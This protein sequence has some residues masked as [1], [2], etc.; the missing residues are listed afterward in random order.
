MATFTVTTDQN[1]D[2]LATKAGGD[3]YNVNGGTLRIDT[4]TRWCANSSTTIGTIGV[5]TISS[6]LGGTVLMDG[7]KVRLIPY[8]SGTG[9]V[10][11]AGT[12]ISQGGVSAT[13]LC[14]M[15][16]VNAV[17]TA[18]G[19]AMPATGFIKVKNKTGGN[20]AAGALSGI[21]ASATGADTVG[22]IEV[23]ADETAANA[24]TI[25]RL[26]KWQITGD[27]YEAGTT[28]GS[29][30]QTFQLPNGTASAAL[31]TP[32]VW[33]ETSSG[34]GEYEFW[35]ALSTANGFSTTNQGTDDRAK[36]VQ[37][38]TGG[39]IRIGSDGTNNIGHLPPTGCKVRIPN[40]ILTGNASATRQTAVIP[41]STIA[42]RFE[43]LTTSA[44]VI[45][46]DK[47]FIHWYVNISQA[48][49]VKFNYAGIFDGPHI[50]SEVASPLDLKDFHIVPA[51]ALDA[52]VL[53]L[54]SCFAGGTVVDCKWGRAGTVGSGDHCATISYC[55]GQT[56]TRLHANSYSVRTNN[57]FPRIIW[58]WCDNQ[59]FNDC[60]FIGLAA[61]LV[62]CSNVDV[63]NLKY[64][65]RAVAQNTNYPTYALLI[66]T[67]C[68]DV[69]VDGYGTYGST[70]NMH[71][72]S[73]L[74]SITASKNIKIR[75]IGTPSSPFNMGSANAS[76]VVVNHGGNS[77]GI[78]VKRVYVQNTRTGI[79]TTINSDTNVLYENVWG[80]SGDVPN[81]QC[82]NMIQRGMY[83]G[84]TPTTGFTSV[85]GSIF[86]DAF[87]SGTQGRV[88]L[89]MN[90]PTSLQSSYVYDKTFAVGS[91]WTS[92]GSLA[93]KALNNTATFEWPHFIKGYTSGANVATVVTGTNVTLS[94][95]NHGKHTIEYQIDKGSGWNGSWLPFTQASIS[96][97]TGI[98]ATVGFK[99]KIRATC[100]SADTTNAI[101]G[102]YATFTTN[103][104]SQQTQYP[105]DTSTITLTGLKNPTEVRVFNA[106]T[107]TEIAGAETVTSGTFSTVIDRAAYTSID[108][109][110]LSLGYQNIRLLNNS[111]AA[112][113]TIPVQQQLDRQYANP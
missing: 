49:S 113:L 20:F 104:S 93:L 11:A 73:G 90:E 103:S 101:T 91:G 92:T 58:T 39:L 68:N 2:T 81:A 70:A 16:A 112:D 87:I 96:G 38:A 105:L 29:R 99:L 22:W 89:F 86:W 85:Y 62:T 43:T 94:G 13:F 64:C 60:R 66:E 9:N 26:G 40:V 50:I 76:G 8:N 102:I 27:W 74:F 51:N 6:T 57:T 75:N 53:T 48:Y 7:T 4:D 32:G 34:S 55:I 65:D 72:Y 111:T 77:D 19:A 52:Q 24:F 33:I 97:Q 84:G 82:L 110:I 95:N 67:R 41:N 42:T 107:A 36:V 31:R 28:N 5:I 3:T 21:G 17:P 106:G 12:T 108:I 35:P 45:D 25:P 80:D 83:A 14:A 109:A 18:Y 56:W 69:V 71:P 37:D 88:G 46:V 63:N 47:A 10:P 61:N 78:E 1:W 44:G 23:S 79:Y 54:S 15:S 100:N 30:G 98:S 59:T